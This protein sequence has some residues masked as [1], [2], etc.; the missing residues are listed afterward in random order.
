MFVLFPIS[1]VSSNQS[2]MS[3]INIVGNRNLASQRRSKTIWYVLKTKFYQYYIIF[4][5]VT[6]SSYCGVGSG[7]VA[8][9]HY[10][11]IYTGQEST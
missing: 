10:I 3:D 7:M 1:T 6:I 5:Q 4:I 11:N 9:K 2:D 8:L